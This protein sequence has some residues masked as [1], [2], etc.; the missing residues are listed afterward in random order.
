MSKTEY[1]MASIKEAVSKDLGI[2]TIT[3]AALYARIHPHTLKYWLTSGDKEDAQVIQPDYDIECGKYVSFLEFVQALAIREIRMAKKVSLQKIRDAVKTAQETHGIRYPLAKKHTCYLYDKE[4][5]IS[6]THD[7]DPIQLSGGEK[8]QPVMRRIVEVFL[9]DISWDVEGI[10]QSYKPFGIGVIQDPARRFGEPLVE[11]CGA[12]A[13]AL[14]EAA[15]T[16]GGYE[17]AAEVY[18]VQPGDVKIACHYFDYLGGK[19]AA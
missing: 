15:R 14:W 8:G 3:E 2:Y 13:L 9:D 12:S 5:F 17:R 16:E 1:T 10:A 7:D 11:S 19:V 18:G 6:F 4:I